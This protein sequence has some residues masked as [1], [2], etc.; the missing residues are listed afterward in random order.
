MPVATKSTTARS[1]TKSRTHSSL[2]RFFVE[3]KHEP[4]ESVAFNGGDARKIAVVLRMQEGDE[5]EVIDSTAQRFHATLH[6]EGRSVRATLRERVETAGDAI[7]RITLA[8]G[9]PKG[10]KMDFVVEKLT[11]L[12]VAQIV[13]LQSE[14]TV[15]SD[16]SPN[17]IER[18][19]RLAKTAAQQ[20]GRADVPEIGEPAAYA[21]L[22][23]TFKDYD[24]VLLPWELADRVPLREKLPQLVNGAQRILVL[25]GPEGGFSHE[26]ADR[27][28]R[29]G[30]ELISLGSRILRTE[31][32]GLVIV[33]LLTYVREGV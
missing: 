21:H 10:Q 22:L 13:P 32:A 11:E 19:R 12:G 3:G 23:E 1:S 25:I 15:V 27:A 2:N 18:W 5:I 6:F 28:Q 26:E 31:T 14:R 33:A 20:C 9:V 24:C 16:V 7:P 30:A 8:Q 17:K 29:A 4:G